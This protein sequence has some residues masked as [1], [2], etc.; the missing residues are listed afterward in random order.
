[1]LQIKKIKTFHPDMYFV[2]LN[3]ISSAVNS[4]QIFIYFSCSSSASNAGWPRASNFVPLLDPGAKC[5]QPLKCHT[6][7]T[8][9]VRN[10]YSV[11]NLHPCRCRWYSSDCLAPVIDSVTTHRSNSS[12]DSLLLKNFNLYLRQIYRWLKNSFFQL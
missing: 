5:Q 4:I 10:R 3:D 7:Q 11:Y 2:F 6:W 8:R 12:V 1:M 9:G